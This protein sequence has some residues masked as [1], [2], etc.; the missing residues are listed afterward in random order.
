MIC[1]DTFTKFGRRIASTQACPYVV[2]ADTPN[3]IQD[4]GPGELRTRAETMIQT[5]IDGLTLPPAEIERQYKDLVR[6]QIHPD[7]IVRSSVPI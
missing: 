7:R 3:P 6:Q 2:I 1:T 4:L 5:V